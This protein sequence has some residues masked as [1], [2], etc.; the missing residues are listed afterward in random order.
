MGK[1]ELHITV[2]NLFR[3]P[4]SMDVMRSPVSLCTGVTYDRSSIQHWLDAGHDT[5]PATMQTL[6]SKDFIPNLTLRRLINLWAQTHGP[7]SPSSSPSS[8]CISE[9]QA[10]TLVQHLENHNESPKV[11]VVDCLSAIV[12]FA[13]FGDENRRIVAKFE[14][15]VSAIVGV[16]CRG[17]ADMEIMELCVRVLDLISMENSVRKEVHASVSKRFQIFLTTIRMFLRNGSTKSKIE[18]AK[19]L[20]LI[21]LDAESKRAIAENSDLLNELLQ[22][23]RTESDFVLHDAVYSCLIEVSITRSTKAELVG[24]GLVDLLT[25]TLSNRNSPKP[26]AEKA[27]K[28]LSIVSTTAEGRSAIGVD[29]RCAIAIVERM[30]KVSRAATEDA[31]AVV[32]SVCCLLGERKTKEAVGNSN[33]VTKILMVMQSGYSEGHRVRTM[34]LELLRVLRIGSSSSSSSSFDGF[35]FGIGSYVSNTTHIMRC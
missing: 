8:R 2:P 6:P 5:C 32:W 13:S 14:N 35:G 17:S 1:G 16:L 4:I 18:S 24:S 33:G 27:L 20:K 11:F 23:I 29:C 28:L 22:L 10:R 26:A 31:V 15:L 7:P 25:T 12:D 30:M 21:A 3:C 34:C 19:V 9:Q